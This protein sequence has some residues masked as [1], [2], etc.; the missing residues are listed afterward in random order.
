MFAGN[1]G[2]EL[3]HFDGTGWTT[4]VTNLSMTPRALFTLGPKDV[5]VYGTV[6]TNS[7]SYKVVRVRETGGVWTPT[8]VTWVARFGPGGSARMFAD[9]VSSVYIPGANY[10]NG[11]T[12]TELG[13]DTYFTWGP[14]TLW[15]FG[16]QLFGLGWQDASG[17][18]YKYVSASDTWAPLAHGF[19]GALVDFH[20][21]AANRIFL[22]GT[23]SSS[24][25]WA[26]HVLYYD[27]LGFTDLP[28]PAN[29]G[30]LRGVH[31]LPTG[32]VFAV[33]DDGLVIKGP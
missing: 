30:R 12:S 24:A 25:G 9:S 19:S 16:P 28:M 1:E 27:G 33:G 17:F 29:V 21:T 31:A 15:K 18:F 23:I 4:V 10:W 11:T 20:G 8:H 26:G 32:E 2:A 5:L 3:L 14:A 22:V 13:Q 7:T 6:T